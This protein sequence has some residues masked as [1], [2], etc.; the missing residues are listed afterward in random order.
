MDRPPRQAP[1]TRPNG[2]NGRL[3][4]SKQCQL[5]ETG[6]R[7]NAL[8]T[9]H[10]TAVAPLLPV[11]NMTRNTI[12]KTLS[13]LA[14]ALFFASRVAAASADESTSHS[15]H[16]HAP[17][18]ITETFYRCL[19]KADSDTVASAACL[20]A[21]QNRQDKRLNGSYKALLAKLGPE[22]RKQLVFA[23]R[24]WLKLK[25]A[26]GTFENAIY[27]NE[28]MSNLELTQNEVFYTCARA[29]SLEKYLDIVDTQ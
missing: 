22:A 21:E 5:D 9:G 13:T 29:N 4:D 20:T 26:N 25:D 18:G 23:E 15:I 7:G 28:I 8:E 12:V 17:A 1:R 24:A 3:L 11:K 16:Q 27:G 6:A 14:A 19:D 10:A 2:D